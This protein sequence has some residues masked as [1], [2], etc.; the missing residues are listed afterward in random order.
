MEP[1]NLLLITT[2]QQR[3]DSLPCYGLDFMHTPNLDR[4]AHEGMVFDNCYTCAPLCV[5][6]RAA[7]LSGQW[8]STSGAMGNGHWLA[9]DL[10][11]WPG[12]VTDA[13]YRTGTIGKMHFHPWDAPCGF[14]ERII[15]E[16]KRH[17]YLPDDHVQF[18]RQHGME[19]PAP[20]T[21]PEYFE[22]LGAP[23]FP[24]PKALH[25]DGYTGDRAAEWISAYAGRPFAAWVGFAGPHDPYD[26][27]EEMADMYYDAPIPDPVDAGSPR[28]RKPAA[29]GKGIDRRHSGVYR[30]DLNQAT[31]E[32]YRRWRA[33]YYANITLIDEGIGKIL[34]ALEEAGVL[35]NTLIVFT[36]DHG[37]ALGDHGLPFK[38]FFYESMAHVPL[39]MRG[40]GV[41][42]GRR[43]RS[44]VSSIDLVPLFYATC[45]LDAP[46]T[47]QGGDVGDLL[48]DPDGHIRDRV[49]SENTGRAMVYDGRHKY[50]HYASGESELYDLQEAPEEA[51]NLRGSSQLTEVETEMRARLLEHWMG[52]MGQ[53]CQP[54]RCPQD[55]LR[56]ALE[57]EYA[58]ERGRVT[59]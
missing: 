41:P 15:A 47:M 8:P 32:H 33:H 30:Y 24:Y 23:V 1:A 31:P 40:P 38:S 42:A 51:V 27:P 53:Q 59:R 14:Q 39:L 9:D 57:E 22:S 5:P 49:F 29:Q 17:F 21:L 56:A 35:D 16:D 25:I 43:C 2:D 7:W 11:T 45:G 26:P 28:D 50:V 12:Q 52:N 44:L 6:C 58:R 48:A 34:A 36:S 55:P 4:L 20:Y 10:P 37:D 46:G 18:L 3:W 13:G 19:R 54:R